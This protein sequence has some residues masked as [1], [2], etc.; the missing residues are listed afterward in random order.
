MIVDINSINYGEP[1]TLLEK[2]SDRARLA[3]LL[4][5]EAAEDFQVKAVCVL[6]DEGLNVKF[7]VNGACFARCDLCGEA[8]VAKCYCDFTETLNE[9]DEAFDYLTETYNLDGLIDEGIVM[10]T[11]RKV[12]CKE[13]CK[14]LCPVC[15]ANLNK[16]TCDCK[17]ERVATSN[18]FDVL[19]DIFITGGAKNGSTKK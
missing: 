13:D 19:Q 4:G 16:K 18:P 10:S 8:T 5:M 11:P 7:V 9:G 3:D 15:G 17:Q 14:G 12:R 2:I 1:T 6:T